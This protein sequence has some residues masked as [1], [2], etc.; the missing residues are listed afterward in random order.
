MHTI[1]ELNELIEEVNE[2]LNFIE[3]ELDIHPG[4]E[5]IIDRNSIVNEYTC[6]TQLLSEF[7]QSGVCQDDI[8]AL[9]SSGLVELNPLHYSQQKSTLGICVATEAAK[10]LLSKLMESISNLASVVW[11]N[12]IKLVKAITDKTKQVSE[13]L[14]GF[15]SRLKKQDSEA[16]NLPV[17]IQLKRHC[18]ILRYGLV[19]DT[20]LDLCEDVS[21]NVSDYLAWF[22]LTVNEFLPDETNNKSNRSNDKNVALHNQ[23]IRG[24]QGKLLTS[25]SVVFIIDYFKKLE[26][27]DASFRPNVNSLAPTT[28]TLSKAWSEYKEKTKGD[29]ENPI[30]QTVKEFEDSGLFDRRALPYNHFKELSELMDNVVERSESLRFTRTDK[31][32]R[33]KQVPDVMRKQLFLFKDLLVSESNLIQF[34]VSVI[35]DAIVKHTTMRQDILRGMTENIKAEEVLTALGGVNNVVNIHSEATASGDSLV[36]SLN[37]SS[38]VSINKL[39]RALKNTEVNGNI[40]TININHDNKLLV[41]RFKLLFEMVS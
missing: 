28:T 12:L 40:V 25:K 26:I 3:Q 21:K 10:D 39:P 1:S 41:H 2:G 8:R 13:K 7:S 34:V 36:V 29:D 19:G 22:D 37:D 14:I 38:K 24:R 18:D 9:I 32:G 30:S 4:Y 23:Q 11:N 27:L 6:A 31:N 5:S 17:T 33:V 15:F 16:N 20:L 35:T